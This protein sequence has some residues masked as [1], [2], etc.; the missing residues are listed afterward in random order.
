MQ[1]G[2]LLGAT[3][4][5]AGIA[6][7]TMVNKADYGAMTFASEPL[8]GKVI[9]HDLVTEDLSVARKFYAGLFGWSFVDSR[10]PDGRN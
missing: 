1:I 8:H 2:K 7:C 3:L 10:G 9:W 4:L 5:A 6:A